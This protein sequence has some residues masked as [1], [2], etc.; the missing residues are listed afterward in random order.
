M[1]KKQLPPEM[2]EWFRSQ[3]AAGGRKSWASLTPKQRHD[4]AQ[5]AAKARWAKKK[6]K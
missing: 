5:K 6:D 4:R 2:L 3:G 1:N